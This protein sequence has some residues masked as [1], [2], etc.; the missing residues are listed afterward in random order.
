MAVSF[1]AFL[2]WAEKRFDGDVLVS[3][4][5]IKI[6]SPFT[7]DHKHHCWCNPTGGKKGEDRPCGVYHCWKTERKGTL[8]GLVMEVDKCDYDIAMEM[9]GAEDH[10]LEKLEKKL[11]ELMGKPPPIADTVPEEVVMNIE[12]PPH[13]Y[14]ISELE[15]DNYFRNEAEVQLTSR[16]MNPKKFYVCVAGEYRNR[17]IIPYYDREG[18][19]IY[20]NGRFMGNNKEIPRYRG[21]DKSVGVGKGD[22][23]YMPTWWTVGSKVYFCEGEF[24]AES[25]VSAGLQAGAFGGKSITEAQVELMRDY[26]PVICVDNDNAGRDALPKICNFLKSYGINDISYVR[27]PIGYKDWN[28]VLCKFGPNI[29]RKYV[30]DCEK[31]FD[32]WAT[33]EMRLQA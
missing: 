8:V 30:V 3:G 19:V 26:V 23:I 6:N 10:S 14:K 4:H 17:I 5:E 21:P 13:T 25:L 11:E 28:D 9:L 12:F 15:E 31:K 29:L 24:N 2:S 7:E 32:S 22:V 18:R 20:F 27:P 1:D 33:E 16:R